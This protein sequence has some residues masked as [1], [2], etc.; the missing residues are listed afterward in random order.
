MMG[1]NIWICVDEPYFM[2]DKKKVG[3]DERRER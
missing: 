3:L 2:R 1:W